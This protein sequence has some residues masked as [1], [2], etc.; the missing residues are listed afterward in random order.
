V[1]CHHALPVEAA[2]DRND[3]VSPPWTGWSQQTDRARREIKIADQLLEVEPA[4][5]NTAAWA[6]LARRASTI[7]EQLVRDLRVRH[8]VEQS[9]T[10][11]PQPV[12]HLDINYS[13]SRGPE[14]G[15]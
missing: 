10:P 13:A 15:L 9:R 5:T 12:H 3:G 11:T 14:I 7:R 2:L 4:G 6:D 1:W 8:T